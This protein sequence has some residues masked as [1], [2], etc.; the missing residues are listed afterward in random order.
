MSDDPERTEAD[1]RVL[2]M[3]ETRGHEF[4]FFRAVSYLE[5]THRAG[6][7]VGEAGPPARET[8]RFR[9]D[10]SLA[11]PAGDVKSV[12]TRVPRHGLM[13]AEVMTTMLGLVGSSSPLPTWM[14][15]DV[16]QS[17]EDGASL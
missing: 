4:D 13:F 17:E 12:R 2:E 11:F 8:I 9:H 1:Q 10:P 6:A 5:R 7:A 15:E 3:L 14:S 16:L